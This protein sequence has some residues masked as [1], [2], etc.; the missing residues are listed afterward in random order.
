MEEMKVMLS[1]LGLV[2]GGVIAWIVYTNI[3]NNMAKNSKNIAKKAEIVIKRDV[4]SKYA[5]CTFYMNNDYNNGYS[6]SEWL[7]LFKERVTDKGLDK[8]SEEYAA[9]VAPFIN[10]IVVDGK[11]YRRRGMQDMVHA[12]E[13]FDPGVND[14]IS[15]NYFVE[16]YEYVKDAKRAAL[17]ELDKFIKKKE[18]EKKAPERRAAYARCSNCIHERRCDPKVKHQTGSCGGY[19]PKEKKNPFL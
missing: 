14:R 18:Y 1:M 19:T 5:G 8:N 3:R 9:A 6:Q 17:S 7:R 11:F 2:V 15:L 12:L 4:S 16:P 13:Q 10:A